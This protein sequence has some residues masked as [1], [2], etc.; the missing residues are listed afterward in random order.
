[1]SRILKRIA[2]TAALTAFFAACVPVWGTGSRAAADET[3]TSREQLNRTGIRIGVGT[4]S[5]SAEIAEKEFTNA[6]FVYFTENVS[7]YNAV[8]Q[9]KADAF[10]FE[11]SQMQMAIDNGI[12]GVHLL[13]E[14][15]DEEIRIAAGISP[16]SRI[17]DLKAKM[18]A[19][20]AEIKANGTLD[21]M[22]DRW[23]IQRNETMPE[24]APAENPEYT[25]TVGTSGTVPPFSF[26]AGQDLNGY[27]IELAYRFAAWLGAKVLFRV[28]DYDS[29]VPAAVTG[30][31]DCILAN[32]NITPE[33]AEVMPFSDVLYT[34]EIGILV[35]GDAQPAPQYT[36]LEQ[37]NGKRIGVQ[38]GTSFDRVISERLPDASISYF[39]SKADIINALQTG[40]IDAYV[41]DEPVAQLNMAE[42]NRLTY[43]PEY[44]E[45]FEFAYVF[46]KNDSG[47]KLCDQFSEYLR[48]IRED[49]TMAEIE[50]KWF[51]E[52]DSLKTMADY[53][54]FPAPNG[55]IRMATEAQY[56]PFSYVLSNRVS[57][58]DIDI[59]VHFCEAYGYG[60]EITDMT[61]DA[62]LPA[63]QT[64][65]CDFGCG[66]ISITEERKESVLFSEP[67]YSGGTV[68]TVLKAES[69]GTEKKSFWSGISESFEKTFLREDR[70]KLF[71]DGVLN[72]LIITVLSILT[73]TALG[74]GVFMLCRNGNAA[75]NSVT[76]FC[77]WLVQ[78]MPMVVLLMVLY[79][80]VF[81]SV[82]LSGLIV[83]VIGFTL[84]FGSAVFGL[85]KIG[86][87]TVDR[88]Q[89]EAAYALGH[90]NR[91][92]F[93][94][95][96]LPQALPHIMPAYKGEVVGLIKATAIVGYI[97]VQDLTKMGDIVRSRTYE[98]FFPLIAIT[99]IYFVL[100]GLLGF[101][102][103]RIRIR[104]DPKRRS[105]KRILKGVKTS[106]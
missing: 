31:V 55:V 46:P 24:I 91:H 56:E 106:D 74:F 67:N 92:T 101:L 104:I 69:A 85:L 47:R 54:A 81:S 63:V 77:T 102:I 32:L 78:G 59:A 64:G 70:W 4:G 29:I 11:R 58:Y 53:Q 10:V 19:F 80:I 105:S 100:E 98:A 99:V 35:R 34:A 23:V 14:N 89:Y 1:V 8:A 97:A 25:L 73:G 75:A 12:K 45:Q 96:I 20:I 82:A 51:G 2:A 50:A 62:L 33:R 18:N 87:G 30:D 94:R 9:G 90:T 27:D 86:V 61:F 68:M 83:A 84:T 13:D 44:L 17:P 60:L 28:Y 26:Y 37:L 38:T 95:I 66:G 71:A 72:T 21:E 57:G 15:M 93:F 22:Y 88:G 36:S 76:R 42:N 79:Y 65:R 40:K 39:I 16:V 41:V 5:A 3:I 52:D 7:A 49:G 43:L 103:N 48:S 6:Q